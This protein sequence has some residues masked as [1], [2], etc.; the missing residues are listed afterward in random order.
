MSGILV[1]KKI[2]KFPLDQ[3]LFYHLEFSLIYIVGKFF[4]IYYYTHPHPEGARHLRTSSILLQFLLAGLEV[5]V[6][7]Q[8]LLC[9][10]LG[11]LCAILVESASP[12]GNTEPH[13]IDK[14]GWLDISQNSTGSMVCLEYFLAVAG[15]NR[16]VKYCQSK[17]LDWFSHCDNPFEPFLKF[18]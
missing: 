5:T 17:K 15:K 14:L 8:H 10:I 12:L 2:V 9:A 1:K 16:L 4:K 7:F 6:V 3:Y 11:Q 13:S 18:N